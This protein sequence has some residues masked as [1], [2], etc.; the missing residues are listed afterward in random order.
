[1]N[2]F[3]L[4]RRLLD[5]Y[6]QYVTSF[7]RIRD[8]RI[9]ELVER[10]IDAGLL[11]PPARIQLNPSFAPGGTIDELVEAGKLHPLC[12]Q[13]FRVGK[14]T[15][16]LSGNPLQLHHH[17]TRAI[18]TAATGASYVLTTG[19]GSG[20]SL[21][22]TIPIVDHVLR[23]GSGRGVRAIVVYPMNALA[24]S[25][26]Q[27]LQKFLSVGVPGQPVR[28]ARYTGQE[29]REVRDAIIANP[30]DIL[31]T[32]YVM[33]ELMLTRP[34]ERRLIR[35]AD[36][37]RFLVL[38]ELHTYR[39]RQGSD[40][41]M[42]VRRVREA[43]GSGPLQCVGTSATLAG[44]GT[45]GEQ[46]RQIADV[47]ALMFGTAVAPESVIGETLRRATT[48]HDEG[49][50]MTV[51]AIGRRIDDPGLLPGDLD[52][53]RADPLAGWIESRIGLR[54]DPDSDTFVRGEP[55]PIDGDGGLAS[56]LA[57]LTDR[58]T[59]PCAAAIETT[60]MQGQGIIRDDAPFPVFAFRVHQFISRGD[61]VF[62]T[63]E[64]VDQRHL[65]VSGRRWAPG[66]RDKRRLLPLA[67]CRECGHEYY[68]VRLVEGFDEPRV[69]ARDTSDRLSDEAGEAGFLSISADP[70]WPRDAADV[71]SR[72]PDDWLESDLRVKSSSRKYLPRYL[73][74]RSDGSLGEDGHDTVFSPA[75]FRLCIQCGVAHTGR[76]GSD[77]PRLGTLGSEGRSTATSIIG[78]SLIRGLR[79]DALDLDLRARKLLSFTDNRQDASLQAGH[80]NDF[81]EVG[82]LRG[83]LFAAMRA[84]NQGGLAHDELASAVAAAMQLPLESYAADPSARFGARDEVDRA[85]RDVVGYRVY[86]DLERGWRITSPSLEQA[87]LLHIDYAY[88]DD[89]C[90]AEDLWTDCHDA[91]VSATPA[92]REALAQTILDALRRELAVDVHYLDPDEQDRIR[93]RSGQ[94]L[95]GR[96][97]IDEGEE[98]R[99]W[100]VAFPRPRRRDDRRDAVYISG[101]GGLGRL[102]RRRATF[103]ELNE[104]IS[105]QESEQIIRE[106]L[107]ALRAGGLVRRVEVS[108]DVP[109]YRVAASA[110]VWRAGDGEEAPVDPLRVPNPPAVGRAPNEFF[111]D[112]Y[113]RAALQAP[114][115]IG[116]EHTAQVPA[117]ERIE[118]EEAF[119]DGRLPILFCSP[120]MELGVDISELNVV[121]LR[122]VPPTP[123]NYAQRSG[124]AGRSGQP[125]L[126]VTYCST[127]SP[128]DQYFFRRPERMVAGRVAP[129]R[130]DLANED[131]VR[132]HVHALWLSETGVDLHT[133]LQDVLDLDSDDLRIKDH[134][135]VDLS[136]EDAKGRARERARRVV[137]SA[138]AALGGSEW[139]GDSWL[140]EAIQQAPARFDRACDRW[141]EMYRAALA[142]RDEQNRISADVSRTK[143][144]RERARRLRG[145]AETQIELLIS[146]DEKLTQADFYTYRYFA[147]EGFLPGYSFPRLPLAAFIPARR[148][149]RSRDGEFISRP[150][151]LAISE[152]GPRSIIYHEGARYVVNQVTL[153]VEAGPDG[154]TSS[155]PLREAKR[156]E[157][158][159]YLHPVST[160]RNPDLCESCAK[161]LGAPLTRLLRLTNVSTRRRERI[162]SDE[163]ERLRLGYEL[164]SAVRFAERGGTPD[165][166]AS[167][168]S[169]PT[170]GTFELGYGDAATIWRVNLGWARR[171]NPAQHGFV[172]DI[173]S[174]YWARNDDQPDDPE[175]PMSGRQERVV[176]FV[177][178]RRNVAVIR[179]SP[180]PTDPAH[181]IS[182][183]TALTSAIQI[184]YQLEPSELAAEPLPSVQDPRAILL[185]EAA[186]GGAGVLRHLATDPEAIP[187]VAREALRIC[188]FD[189]ETGGDLGQ[190]EGQSERCEAACYDC[191]MSYGNQRYHESLD[192]F[193]VRD[194]LLD[195]AR[196]EV[197]IGP[198]DHYERLLARCESGLERQWLEL[199]R[200]AG[201]PLPDAAQERVPDCGTRPDFFYR[202]ALVAVYVDGPHHLYPERAARDVT[203]N[204]CMDRAGYRVLRFGTDPSEWPAQFAEY[205][206]VLRASRRAA[207]N[208]TS[209]RDSGGL[210][211]DASDGGAEPGDL[212]LYPSEWQPLVQRLRTEAKLTVGPGD[213][214][215]E[216]GRVVGQSVAVVRNGSVSIVLVSA[217]NQGDTDA[218]AALEDAGIPAL[219][220]S[221]SDP[222]AFDLIAHALGAAS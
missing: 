148:R 174:G 11:W 134:I 22:Y 38:D 103:P 210:G 80:F 57:I 109:G 104:K 48:E 36:A 116:R 207:A 34:Y 6:R 42:L 68:S 46:Q 70:P 184:T 221:P 85:L 63:L 49:D 14:T 127:G 107:E 152:F 100:S 169:G 79:E 154:G 128:H 59:G 20:K 31:L 75:P 166:L 99:S 89:V 115:L 69:E 9:R 76:L 197:Q 163:E 144:E 4:R 173:Q 179:L 122:N 164:V 47:A 102:V 160:D 192:R 83:G 17:Q 105:M 95:A 208:E 195:L 156:C 155:L 50:P 168:A 41:A 118:R 165:V 67:F 33:L 55:L 193:A 25:Q 97:A 141:R 56:E 40:V 73:R 92:V 181:V 12:R 182:L 37:L 159:G 175:D 217:L 188:H 86:R 167:R 65:T 72:L 98:M 126:V 219:S 66:G 123:A 16:D 29:S 53:F 151:F 170:G 146:T 44:A 8:A 117:A 19:T 125:A 201:L 18:E 129:P 142:Q 10:E 198:K 111:L 212:D 45:P 209:A 130:L 87:G 52:G 178:D 185:Y 204:T 119:R 101:R 137:A 216:A 149:G 74:V 205:E 186:E 96:W 120:T 143:K 64:D 190:A 220:V 1:M 140:D 145:Q 215:M 194:A 196:S 214:V 132:A 203:Q 35:D 15:D 213:D 24:N 176:P 27:E 51:A 172:L 77:F 78:S 81:I 61:T 110:M 3:A 206:A 158:C 162:T 28:F 138:N 157:S 7:V 187:T 32:N 200:D 5:D 88:L 202:A 94:H 90:S 113:R 177:E 84:G 135:A 39:G 23:E 108:G 189:P 112:L 153:P 183:M 150:R 54:R 82:V 62:A 43:S 106:V 180:Q 131:L 114:D 161:P 93:Q 211:S 136:R 139:F 171:A 91:L 58:E 71:V 133:S 21:T 13:I 199:V 121:N 124:R 222:E 2:V 191:L 26:L 30:P 60:L 218:L 147:S